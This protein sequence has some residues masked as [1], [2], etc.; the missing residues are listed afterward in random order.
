MKGTLRIPMNNKQCWLFT[1]LRDFKQ[2]VRYRY[3]WVCY[4]KTRPRGWP[5][6]SKC[7]YS[8]A[9]DGGYPHR[10]TS[11]THQ[12]SIVNICTD[13]RNRCKMKPTKNTR[14][15]CYENTRNI[16]ICAHRRRELPSRFTFRDKP[17]V[18][19]IRIIR[20]PRM[21]NIA[22]LPKHATSNIDLHDLSGIQDRILGW[23]GVKN[24]EAPVMYFFIR[25]TQYRH[26]PGRFCSSSRGIRTG[27]NSTE[28]RN[29]YITVILWFP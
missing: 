17:K 22:P 9:A 1:Q 3:P 29:R 10:T 20:L 24:S 15:H 6:W 19:D 25:E 13:H 21:N 26:I 5:L 2:R 4:T 8:K 11:E 14:S 18:Y 23:R 12:R 7:D 16:L 27:F 28:P